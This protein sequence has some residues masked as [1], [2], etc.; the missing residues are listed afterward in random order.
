MYF[1][2]WNVS[3]CHGY[4]PPIGEYPLHVITQGTHQCGWTLTPSVC[5]LNSKFGTSL[6]KNACTSEFGTSPK[7]TCTSEFGVSR[8]VMGIPPTGEYPLH[9][10]QGMHWI[11]NLERLFLRMRVLPNSEH[12]LLLKITFIS[13]WWLNRFWYM[14]L[15]SRNTSWGIR[16]SVICQ[17]IVGCETLD[18]FQLPLQDQMIEG[19]TLYF[20][21]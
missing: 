20:H 15:L 13:V 12:L 16:L 4:L 6:S 18:A 14:N 2:I 1:R 19:F 9:V 10:T 3:C 5:C 7:N 8:V 11:P 17:L 21:A